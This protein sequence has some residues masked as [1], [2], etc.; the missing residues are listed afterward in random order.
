MLFLQ[1]YTKTSRFGWGQSYI[2]S[3][4]T[5]KNQPF[6]I[7]STLCFFFKNTQKSAVFDRISRIVF[8]RKKPKISGVGQGQLYG[9]SSKIHKNQPFWIGLTPCFFFKNT[10]KSTVSGRIEA[11]GFGWNYPKNIETCHTYKIF[12]IIHVTYSDFTKNKKKCFTKVLF[13]N[14]SWNCKIRIGWHMVNLENIEK[15]TRLRWRMVIPWMFFFGKNVFYY[16]SAGKVHGYG[17]KGRFSKKITL[18]FIRDT[19]MFFFQWITVGGQSHF[20]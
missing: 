14:F 5:H 12:M 19:Y 7:G 6:R 4:K 10:W 9:F 18:I 17:G 2:F 20:F 13:I 11:N 1:K 16:S 8:V 3:S 15:Q